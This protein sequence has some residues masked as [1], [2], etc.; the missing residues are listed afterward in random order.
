MRGV[1]SAGIL[2]VFLEEGFDPFEMALGTSSGACNLASFFARQHERNIRCYRDI[3][4][5]P[6]TVSFWRYVRGGHLMDLDWLWDRMEEE[7]P[8]DQEAVDAHPARYISVATCALTGKPIYLEPSAPDIM[9]CLKGSCA[10]PLF[11]R[12]PV[13]WGEYQMFDGGSSDPI[14][15]RK[16]YEMGARRILV[17]RSRPSDTVKT[18]TVVRRVESLIMTRRHPALARAMRTTAVSA[19]KE[20]VTMAQDPPDGCVVVQLAPPSELRTPLYTRDID[21][22]QADYEMGRQLAKQSLP[23]LQEQ[24]G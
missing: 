4:S 17:L 12:G 18:M 9:R 6:T 24:F 3:M 21:C 7:E 11:Y 14:P 2:D 15:V 19:Y 20:A 8:L 16:A 5:R 10:L 1:F 22:L 23:K 13:R